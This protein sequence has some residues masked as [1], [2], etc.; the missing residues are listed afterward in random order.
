MTLSAKYNQKLSKFLSKG[1]ERSVS[2]NE[3]NKRSNWLIVLISSNKDDNAKTY[4]TRWYYLPKYVIKNYNVVI[5]GKQ[6]YDQTTDSD[7]KTFEQIRKLTIGEDEDYTTEF[8][9]DYEYIKNCYRLIAVDFSR[10]RQ[11]DGDPR[12]IQEIEFIRHLKKA[13]C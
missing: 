10:Q 2:W 1:F 5:N 9:L 13:M 8:L 11:L 7:I 4:E 3:Y 6:I 12:A